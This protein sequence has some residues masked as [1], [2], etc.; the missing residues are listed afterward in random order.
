MSSNHRVQHPPPDMSKEQQLK[1]M[2]MRWQQMASEQTMDYLQR[3]SPEQQKWFLGP[4]STSQAGASDPAEQEVQE[5]SLSAVIRRLSIAERELEMEQMR[6]LYIGHY[7]K[8]L[9][10]LLGIPCVTIA[11]TSP[12]VVFAPKNLNRCK[13]RVTLDVVHSPHFHRG[14]LPWV[15]NSTQRFRWRRCVRQCLAQIPGFGLLRLTRTFYRNWRLATSWCGSMKRTRTEMRRLWSVK[16][17]DHQEQLQGLITLW[18]DG[19]MAKCTF[20]SRRW[21]RRA[22]TLEAPT[23]CCRSRSR[24]KST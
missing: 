7:V 9:Y 3:M 16:A 17:R 12:I 22:R 24:S 14:F 11:C 4:L 6:V 20:N 21:C 23:K 5:D 8:V 15:G 1:Y 2:N 10:I 19:Q 13:S 18:G